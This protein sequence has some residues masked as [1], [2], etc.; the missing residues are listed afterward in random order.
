M[1]TTIGQVSRSSV[2]TITPAKIRSSDLPAQDNRLALAPQLYASSVGSC[3]V[4]DDREDSLMAPVLP[5]S[6]I[7]FK[8][9]VRTRSGFKWVVHPTEEFVERVGNAPIRLGSLFVLDEHCDVG[10]RP[11]CYR[12]EAQ[13]NDASLQGLAILVLHRVDARSDRK[14]DTHWPPSVFHLRLPSSCV[15]PREFCATSSS[16]QTDRVSSPMSFGGKANAQRPYFW[17]T[18]VPLAIFGRIFCIR[19]LSS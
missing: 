7:T 5:T 4:R 2:D 17:S 16:P 18:V 13:Y 14:R 12:V 3:Q 10:D 8:G 1:F 6:C 9:L 19:G 15:Q 11:L